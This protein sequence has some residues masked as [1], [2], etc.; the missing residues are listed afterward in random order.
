MSVTSATS[1]SEFALIEHLCRLP[2]FDALDGQFC[3]ALAA[4]A[5]RRAFETDEILF[6]E[7]DEC[8]GL[9]IV[10]Q[11]RVKIYKMS[12]DGR[13]H[14]LRLAG[15][16]QSFNEIPVLDGG[17]NAASVAALSDGI[18]WVIGADVIREA[19]QDNHALALRIVEVLAIRVRGLIAQI[20]GLAL[21]SVMTRLARFLL[22][23][24]ENPSLDG[25]GVTRATIAAHLATTP[26]TISRVLRTLEEA[27]AIQ[28]DRHRIVIVNEDVLRGIALV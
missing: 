12:P 14:I 19:I 17:P 11:G 27:G 9:W 2:Y 6:I 23:Q 13:E 26:E 24:A 3:H 15:P 28:F 8:A 22:E 4:Q 1:S 20:E 25:P 10:E 5:V 16:G 21:H 7:G 18:A